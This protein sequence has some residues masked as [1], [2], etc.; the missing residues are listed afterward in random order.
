MSNFR[1]KLSNRSHSLINFISKCIII[2][3]YHKYSIFD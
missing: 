1:N 3:M 2:I